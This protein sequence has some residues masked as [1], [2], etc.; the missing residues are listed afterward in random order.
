MSKRIVAILLSV[1][2]CFSLWASIAP[3]MAA[4]HESTYLKVTA[5]TNAAHPG[6]TI[7]FTITMGPVSDMGSMQMVLDIPEGLSYVV[8]SGRLTEGLR[9]TLG[10]DTADWTEISRMINGVASASD[11]ESDSDTVLGYFQCSVDEGFTGEVDVRLTELEFYS[12]Q[13]WTD[14]TDRFFVVP[15]TISISP[16]SVPAT[17]IQLNKK[18]ITLTAGQSEKLMVVVS[19]EDST[20]E[21]VWSTEDPNTVRV[22]QDGT[23]YGLKEGKTVVIVTA[24]KAT[25]S[26][27]VTVEKAP[28]LHP[29]LETIEEKESTCIAQGWDAYKQ[30][31]DCG[32][33][34]NMDDVEIDEVPYRSLGNHVGG[35]ATC[36]KQAVCTVC[37]QLYGTLAPHVWSE[38]YL[39]EN[40]DQEKHY[41]VCETC[42]I[43]DEGEDHIPGPDATEDQDQICTVCGYIMKNATGHVHAN[44]LTY[45]EKVAETC[46]VDG[47]KAYYACDCGKFFTDEEGTQEIVQDITIWKRIPATGH[48]PELDDGDCTTAIKCS[49]CGEIVTPGKPNHTGGTATCTEQAI[50]EVCGTAYGELADHIWSKT[51]LAENADVHKHYHVCEVCGNKDAG[52]AHIAGPEATETAPQVCTVCNY[53]IAPV[54]DHVHKGTRVEGTAPSCTEDGSK[55][56]YSCTCGKY[57]EDPDCAVEIKESINDWKRIPATGHVPNLDDGDCTTAVT[58]SVCNEVVVPARASHTGGTATCIERA[59]CE[60]CGTAYGELADH[61]WTDTYLPANA[62]KDKHYHICEICKIKD[63]GENH[64]PGPAATEDSPQVCTVCSYELAPA[65]EHVHN[66]DMQKCDEVNHWFECR[67]GDKIQISPHIYDNALDDTCNTCGHVRLVDVSLVD[68]KL[69]FGAVAG[70]PGTAYDTPEKVEARISQILTTFAGYIADNIVLYDV[71]LQFSLDDGHSWINAT[72]ENFPRQGITIT[73]P[74]PEGTGKSTHDFVVVHM[75]TTTSDRLETLAGQTEQPSVTKTQ[76]G[77]QVTLKGLSPVGIA[78]KTAQVNSGAGDTGNDNTPEPTPPATESGVDLGGKSQTV[79]ASAN[80]DRVPQEADEDDIPNNEEI[81]SQ[82]TDPELKPTPSEPEQDPN[83]PLPETDRAGSEDTTEQSSILWWIFGFVTL[84]IVVIIGLIGY[85]R[86]KINT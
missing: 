15:A 27:E 68:S 59:K 31:P 62:D 23:V 16:A 75:F 29:N 70:I 18:T 13:T 19:P 69:E 37:G 76:N 39:V 67:C 82:G 53:V 52:E 20:D 43:K 1:V 3:A 21:V 8:G 65:L 55:A 64:I 58:C 11:Y 49:V 79:T 48:V 56:Y 34:F 74:Y 47:S 36:A 32:V 4:N 38:T 7:D 17:S 9:E 5:N 72:E 6:D 26:C 80:N 12:C 54:L 78:W 61:I 77:L 25:D 41:H 30:C 81:G 24:G 22:E 73:L 66:F 60:V 71:K 10:Y 35:T 42:G 63:T 2:L 44:H 83:S 33:L 86:R 45:H 50:C 14:H 85:R 57:F 28:C 46:T 84:L 51:Y 40:A